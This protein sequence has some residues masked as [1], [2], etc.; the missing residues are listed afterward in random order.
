MQIGVS[1]KPIST[2][3]KTS[4]QQV[5]IIKTTD[6]RTLM[7]LTPNEEN[8]FSSTN[9]KELLYGGKTSPKLKKIKKITPAQISA[10][11][12]Y[13]FDEIRSKIKI[14]CEKK[15]NEGMNTNVYNNLNNGNTNGI[16]NLHEF[17]SIQSLSVKNS[18]NG[19]LMTPMLGLGKSTKLIKE[20]DENNHISKNKNK[21]NHNLDSKNRTSSNPNIINSEGKSL[22]KD[23]IKKL[24]KKIEVLEE[25][26]KIKE[27]KIANLEKIINEKSECARLDKLNFLLNTLEE[28]IHTEIYNYKIY[29]ENNLKQYP[30]L[31][32]NSHKIFSSNNNDI[33][34]RFNEK[35]DLT[36]L[37]TRNN[38]KF[39]SNNSLLHISPSLG[40]GFNEKNNFFDVNSPV[41]E[42][43]GNPY[44][45]K[46]SNTNFTA[47]SHHINNNLNK[48]NMQKKTESNFNLN[49][50]YNNL[51]VNVENFNNMQEKTRQNNTAIQVIY[52]LEPE[53]DSSKN[54]VKDHLQDNID[55][56]NDDKIQVKKIRFSED[57]L[58]NNN[59]DNNNNQNMNI[60]LTNRKNQSNYDINNSTK[61]NH[62]VL[63][64]SLDNNT[65]KSIFGK[66]L[67]EKDLD[68]IKTKI[69]LQKSKSFLKQLTLSYRNRNNFNTNNNNNNYED[70]S[71]NTNM[72]NNH[73]IKE[74]KSFV[75]QIPLS[76]V[77]KSVDKKPNLNIDINNEVNYENILNNTTNKRQRSRYLSDDMA[78][79]N[80]N[81]QKSTNLKSIFSQNLIALL[82]KIINLLNCLRET[83]LDSKKYSIFVKEKEKQFNQMKTELDAY[84]LREKQSKKI[85]E[86]LKSKINDLEYEKTRLAKFSKSDQIL[87][88]MESNS[89]NYFAKQ[90]IDLKRRLEIA[91]MLLVKKKEKVS[92]LNNKVDY[93]NSQ[94]KEILKSK[95]YFANEEKRMIEMLHKKLVYE[96]ITKGEEKIIDF[97]TSDNAINKELEMEEENNLKIP[98]LNYEMS[99]NLQFRIDKLKEDYKEI[100][101]DI[102]GN[103][104]L[105][106]IK[107]FMAFDDM[108]KENTL[109]FIVDQLKSYIN[110]SQK[111]NSLLFFFIHSL[112]YSKD[113]LMLQM[114]LKFTD[115]FDAERVTLWAF[116]D[117][118]NQYNTMLDMN[119]IIVDAN[120]QYFDIISKNGIYK[121]S[122][123]NKEENKGP[124]I[125]F[126]A[127]KNS[128]IK[129]KQKNHN[130]HLLHS[131]SPNANEFSSK[132]SS[133]I[134][135][136]NLSAK[137]FSKYNDNEKESN[138]E[139]N[140]KVDFNTNKN[141]SIKSLSLKKN[142][143]KKPDSLIMNN[144]DDKDDIANE[145]NQSIN[146]NNKK[147]INYTNDY[148]S[149]WFPTNKISADNTYQ[150]KSSVVGK[151]WEASQQK[152]SSDL[153]LI[154]EEKIH[155]ESNNKDFNEA[156]DLDVAGVYNKKLNID[157]SN[158]NFPKNQNI[159]TNALLMNKENNN[160]N[161]E[162]NQNANDQGN[163]SA[164]HKNL[165]G[166]NLKRKEFRIYPETL[167]KIF[168]VNSHVESILA[169]PIKNNIYYGFLEII[170]SKQG[171]FSLDDE[172]LIYI[173]SKYLKIFLYKYNVEE[174][175]LKERNKDMIPN[176][177]IKIMSTRN[178][179]DLTKV[180]EEKSNE[181]ISSAGAKL[182]F[183]D[184]KK[185]ELIYY[186]NNNNNR[187]VRRAIGGIAG[188]SIKLN[189]GILCKYPKH[190][191]NYNELID[192]EIKSNYNCFY[193]I[194]LKKE[195]FGIYAVFQFIMIREENV[196]MQGQK[197]VSTHKIEILDY[198]REMAIDLLS[199]CLANTVNCISDNQYF[200]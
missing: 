64:D 39:I 38:N 12:S 3:P 134:E 75:N 156:Y 107:I 40:V 33:S 71:S 83:I 91:C 123:I 148:N 57:I 10:R 158:F 37:N 185:N 105:E 1:K 4:T 84:K 198:F 104:S 88:M 200:S 154:T 54:L 163:I 171:Y 173:I 157:D 50:K 128:F 141:R 194:P 143:S 130:S 153:M 13:N 51:N 35:T 81:N 93:L 76:N 28:K 131:N 58:D 103:D 102:L 25:R 19:Y 36:H 2:R 31:N 188:L 137:N 122:K 72:E 98:N 59:N 160:N 82:E 65:N 184:T 178:F 186:K 144:S 49:S 78:F 20:K 166:D 113:E 79:E 23:T 152:K 172:Y 121:K 112:N 180:F 191:E 117:Y 99:E 60:L 11:C 87:K 9:T 63:F 196:E 118:V 147:N 168:S 170:N 110:F 95:N 30:R 142:L 100:M 22:E 174:A 29:A 109:I 199:N 8:F 150:I 6:H 74:S 195:N 77:S 133:N 120:E 183:I 115:I 92:R 169:V 190:D 66:S 182:V 140:M 46:I 56:C 15:D 108:E 125:D 53:E 5:K 18:T 192:I 45:N 67:L 32:T 80:E 151:E 70:Y 43:I 136:K 68:N 167:E 177:I 52:S 55:Q 85:Y 138:N 145:S 97:L 44:I 41:L 47:S 89:D 189:T 94:I 193:S 149:G 132:N 48:N 135:N 187:V 161:Y 129:S 7:C 176:A 127:K 106:F 126:D 116:D 179:F 73:N 26:L 24:I 14:D 16:G 162:Y 181:L 111:L 69:K 155:L 96:K 197:K 124:E 42:Q 139:N 61:K 159:A 119:K 86:N 34:F 175:N 17:K 90:N 27:V 21:N 62:P 114:R 164:F 146:E 101:K 165:I